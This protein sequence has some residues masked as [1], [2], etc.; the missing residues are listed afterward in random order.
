[1]TENI[2]KHKI[3]ILDFGSQ[4]TQLIARRVR[5]SQVYCEIHPFN[6][7]IDKIR[8]FAAE[9]LILSGGPSSIYD[10]DSPFADREVLNLGIPILGICYGMQYLSHV[11]GGVVA[12]ADDREYGNAVINI[13]D[14]SDLF[15]GFERGSEE[16]VWMSH[17]DR[18]DRIPDGFRVLATSK[19]SPVAAMADSNRK[20]FG[21][22]FHPEVA[23]TPNGM[24]ILKNFL[25]RVCSC[26]PSWTMASFAKQTVSDLRKKLEGERVVCGLSG[27]VDSSV[28]AVLLNE[29]IGDNLSCIFVD[30]G[31]LRK[32]ES[33]EV[34]ETFKDHYKMDVRL[35]D[36]SDLFL[37]KLS[38]VTD[39][40]KEK[41]YRP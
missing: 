38:G 27:G 13:L 18:I 39:P 37:E 40:E 36:A 25:F 6:I 11:L 31:L 3:L 32:G 9:G 12:K 24:K 1:M 23:H 2:Y 34:M 8:K 16:Q 17:G 28:A 7:S 35:V 4:Y 5:E 29:A 20:F 15:H 41:D 19:N 33:Q 26:E 30:N 10:K 22:Q 21:V 14:D